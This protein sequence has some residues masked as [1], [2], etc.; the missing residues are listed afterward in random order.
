MAIN[1]WGHNIVRGAVVR[2]HA[3]MHDKHWTKGIVLRLL[4]V[5]DFSRAYGRQAEVMIVTGSRGESYVHEIGISD[6]SRI[7]TAKHVP[8]QAED[9]DRAGWGHVVIKPR[10]RRAR[11]RSRR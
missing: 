3:S 1:R 8:E 4:P 9:P 7:G 2:F 6:L 11:R 10:L 5:D